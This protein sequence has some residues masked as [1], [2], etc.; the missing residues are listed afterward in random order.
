[1]CNTQQLSTFS[2]LL[3]MTL[4]SCDILLNDFIY[5]KDL[6]KDICVDSFFLLPL[7]PD[8]Q[9]ICQRGCRFFNI[10]YLK[11]EHDFNAT[12]DEC[13][14]S[15]FESYERTLMRN[16]C[17]IGC[18]AMFK[19]KESEVTNVLLLIDQEKP[20][21]VIFLEPEL[22]LLESDILSDPL[23]HSQI[24]IGYNIEYK[25]PETNIRTMPIVEFI[26]MERETETRHQQQIT[27]DWLDC[28]SRNSGIPKW[29]LLP[30]ILTA[31]VIA[32]WLSFGTFT[33]RRDKEDIL[34]DDEKDEKDGADCIKSAYCPTEEPTMEYVKKPLPEIDMV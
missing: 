8:A 28:A 14:D 11:D 7:I 10:I 23:I 21:N 5:E 3:I 4:V 32:V 24:E 6:C 19:K 22:E 13:F 2:F 26:E 9:S 1:M 17:V 25:I 18:K 12:R 34:L 20:K 27:T 16:A 31:V 30:A 33:E 15:C 29:I